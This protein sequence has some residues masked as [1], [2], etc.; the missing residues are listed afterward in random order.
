MRAASGMPLP[1]PPQAC[2][3]SWRAP[4]L[5][6]TLL[7]SW[8]LFTL[9]QE[10]HGVVGQGGCAQ[11]AQP[12]QPEVSSGAGCCLHLVLVVRAEWSGGVGTLHGSEAT[13]PDRCFMLAL[14]L[15]GRRTMAT[16]PR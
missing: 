15:A 13:V 4:L 16:T 8:P 2:R 1:G 10:A 6:L 12:A 9:L 5:V 14:P 7:L 3:R 11:A